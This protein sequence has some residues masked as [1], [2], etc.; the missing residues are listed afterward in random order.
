MDELHRINLELYIKDLISE[1]C[2]FESIK[3]PNSTLSSINQL[4][5]LLKY[6]D[7][8]IREIIIRKNRFIIKMLEYS[9]SNFENSNYVKG[10]MK[11]L[12]FEMKRLSLTLDDDGIT[13]SS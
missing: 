8:D 10:W 12:L 3:N 9:L 2:S 13:P 1:I 11:Y 7:S 5:W 6:E 4:I